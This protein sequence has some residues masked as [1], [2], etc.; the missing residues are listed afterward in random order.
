[1]LFSGEVNVAKIILATITGGLKLENARK[2]PSP[3]YVAVAN[4]VF[5]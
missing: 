2:F 3:E 4:C 1:M 5:D